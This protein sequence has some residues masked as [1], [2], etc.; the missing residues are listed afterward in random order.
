MR[1]KKS[2]MNYLQKMNDYYENRLEDFIFSFSNIDSN[3]MIINELKREAI[4][5]DVPIIRNE[6][7]DILSILIKINKPENI[8]ELGTG[9]GYSTLIMLFS[10]EESKITTIENYKKRIEIAKKNFLKYDKNNNIFLIESDITDSLKVLD[11]KFDFIFLDAAKA[12]YPIWFEY[13]KKIINK[14]GIIFADNIFRDGEVIE[15]HF[16]IRKRNRTIHKRMRE[17][18]QILKDDIDFDTKIINIGDGI[19]ISIKK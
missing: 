7:A 9:I 18:L 17:F 19:T 16:A 13:L 15:S 2:N 12:Q 8:L 14:N 4:D 3:E 1:V 6:T 10:S 5:L 11:K